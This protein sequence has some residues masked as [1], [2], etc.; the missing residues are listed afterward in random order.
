MTKRSL[1]YVISFFLLLTAVPA[2]AEIKWLTLDDGRSRA[3]SEQKPMIVDFFYGKGCSRCENLEKKVYENP[4]I[5]KRISNDFIPVR[6]DLTKKLTD[7]ETDL[8]NQY[9]FKKDCL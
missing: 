2:R 4:D 5:A 6:V 7:E 1:L 8:G 9:N 3:A